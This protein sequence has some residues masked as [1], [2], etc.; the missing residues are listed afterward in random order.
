[1]YPSYL[2]YHLPQIYAFDFEE[3]VTGKSFTHYSE[4]RHFVVNSQGNVVTFQE[5]AFALFCILCLFI[6][7]FM[8][9]FV[10]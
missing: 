5:H 8:V 9:C 6:V 3:I 1:M 4:N 10:F 2:I 7:F